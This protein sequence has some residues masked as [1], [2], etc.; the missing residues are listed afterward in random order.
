MLIVTRLAGQ[1]VRIGDGIRVV[2]ADIRGKQV[3]LA[4][5]APDDGKLYREELTDEERAQYRVGANNEGGGQ[6]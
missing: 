6:G 4:L 3:H 2:L 5:E 1:A